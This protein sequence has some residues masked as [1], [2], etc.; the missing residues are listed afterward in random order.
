[1]SE[2]GLIEMTRQRT[3]DNISRVLREPCFYCQGEGHLLSG[4]SICYEAF[5]N[6]EREAVQ[7]LSD[8]I[9]LTVHPRLKELLLDE[10]RHSLNE[11][12]QRTGKRVSIHDD[13]TLH[14]EDYR[15]EA[16]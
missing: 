9:S 12:E 7:T 16:E 1:M 15:V 4:S 10:E 13:P 8:S 5:R 11:L 14:I 3:R 2:L 6:V